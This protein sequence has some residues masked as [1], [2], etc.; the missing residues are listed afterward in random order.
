MLKT[1][2]AHKERSFL[3]RG[4]RAALLAGVAVLLALRGEAA[5]AAALVAPDD[6]P[7]ENTLIQADSVAYDDDKNTVTASGNVEIQRG[8]RI[9]LADQ[10]VYDRN[11]EIATATG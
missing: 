9:L 5:H 10:I 6:A 8:A 7:D 2:P 11:S 1:G 3:R 4:L